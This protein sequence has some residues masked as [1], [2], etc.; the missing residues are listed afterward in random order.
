MNA[1]QEPHSA[2]NLRIQNSSSNSFVFVVLDFGGNSFVFVVLDF[3]GNSFVFV[4]QDL[5]ETN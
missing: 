1:V 2:S 4:V 3:G 5:S